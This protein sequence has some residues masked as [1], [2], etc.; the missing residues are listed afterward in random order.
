MKSPH[1][2]LNWDKEDMSVTFE[3]VLEWLLVDKRINQ[4]MHDKLTAKLT[5]DRLDA[6]L[7][8][9]FNE[10]NEWLITVIN[11]AMYDWAIDVIKEDEL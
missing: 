3:S 9:F 8:Q 6:L 5:D 1:T 11:D 4:E 2:P 10:Y 7:S